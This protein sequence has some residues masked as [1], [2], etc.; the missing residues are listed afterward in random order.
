MGIIS[1]GGL[2]ICLVPMM[3]LLP[4]MLVGGEPIAEPRHLPG[5]LDR[6]DRIERVWLSRPW[7]VAGLV[8]ALCL[9]A[10][11]R[12]G[13]VQFDY[14]LLNMQSEGLSAV[15]FEKKLIDS[16]NKSV[17]FGA[18]VADSLEAAVALEARLTNLTTVASADL[19]GIEH[20][21]QYLTEDPTR[22]LAL[23]R[24]IREEA[25][26]IR[27]ATVDA[28]PADLPALRQTLFSL[29]GYLGLAAKETEKEDPDIFRRLIGLRATVDQLGRTIVAADAKKAARKIAQFQSALFDDVQE[30]FRA[31]RTQDAS[32]GLGTADLPSAMRN[33]FLGVTGK[34]LV[35][36]YP[37]K[38]V[39]QRE[40]QKE[41]VSQL[42]QIDPDVTGT[43]VQLYEYTTLL[44]NSYLEAAGY[45]LIAIAILVLLHFRS[46]SCVALALLPVLVGTLWM[47][48]FMGW[49]DIP[50]NPANIM[51]LPLVIGIGVTNGIHVL[52]R[53]EEE[54]SPGIL[55]KSTGKAVLVS[56]FTTV[57]GFGSLI[58]AKHQ[59]ISSLGYVM[60]V[61]VWNCMIAGLIFLPAVLTLLI[62]SG[63]RRTR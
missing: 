51:T 37:K 6:R 9:L 48:G 46:L 3:T 36:V 53:Y 25:S 11:V 10:A 44:K 49:F 63:W 4:A 22:K 12:A 33:R 43:P 58:L 41:F 54:H 62:R 30:T 40:N 23:I 47:V 32:S 55:A 38:D 57:A 7:L 61:G 21:S 17:L 13:R 16:A 1:G 5:A 34:Y 31:I 18:V 39:W 14:N 26:Q 52:N 50:F 2:L 28:E 29:Q 20:M 19:G 8:G 56:G 15:V 27:F 35:Q 59:G 45:A 60:S 42:R 24:E